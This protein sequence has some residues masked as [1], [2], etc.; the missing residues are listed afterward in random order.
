M[1]TAFYVSALALGATVAAS[2]VLPERAVGQV[3]PDTSTT[4]ISEEQTVNGRLLESVQVEADH[5][6]RFYQFE[7]GEV[8]IRETLSLEKQQ[9]PLLD[10]INPM[11]AP[12][13]YRL[14]KP[15]TAVPDSIMEANQ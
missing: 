2:I 13:A 10:R 5:E 9:T 12:E 8:G 3:F 14:L 6:I 4:A 1:K 15:G 11:S 7:N